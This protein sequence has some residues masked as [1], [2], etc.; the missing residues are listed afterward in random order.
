M[1]NDVEFERLLS[2]RP[3]V[4]ELTTVGQFCIRDH[5]FSYYCK[6]YEPEIANEFTKKYFDELY[7]QFVTRKV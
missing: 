7:K 2:A 3:V 4:K 6:H 1:T 5:V